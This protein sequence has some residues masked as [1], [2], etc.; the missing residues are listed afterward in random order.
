M[1][2]INYNELNNKLI[3]EEIFSQLYLEGYI[4]IKNVPNFLNHYK[5]YLNSARSFMAL[6]SDI[7]EKSTPKNY[8]ERGW[9]YG[10]ERLDGKPDIH[11]GSY[12][13]QF[14]DNSTNIWPNEEFRNNYLQLANTIFNVSRELIDILYPDLKD[15]IILPTGRM[16][17]Y[18]PVNDIIENN[19]AWCTLHR[20][21]SLITGLCPAAY[22]KDGEYIPNAEINDPKGGLF[23]RGKR[24]V[25]PEDILLFQVGE[26]LQL[27][28]NGKIT[29]TL[30]E[31]KKVSGGL[32]RYTFALFTNPE[33]SLIMSSTDNS[34]S[35]RFK[36]G[37]SYGDWSQA[38][39]KK[40]L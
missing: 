24:I 2:F 3:K 31:V 23:I 16:L 22:F 11:K 1:K 28:T 8:Y 38:S 9:S 34:Y 4:G 17:Y 30:H 13:A 37:M 14:P 39:L 25:V 10:V 5:E 19:D 6:S 33:D 26:A 36:S 7:R 27:L 12:Y 32:E 40:Y 35:D 29:A 20:D 21:H 15:K 18:G